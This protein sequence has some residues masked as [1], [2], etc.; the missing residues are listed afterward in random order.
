MTLYLMYDLTSARLSVNQCLNYG[1][2]RSIAKSGWTLFQKSRIL[3][4]IFLGSF[5]L[6]NNRY[7]ANKIKENTI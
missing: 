6:C 7:S 5:G 4:E 3:S 2:M 1:H